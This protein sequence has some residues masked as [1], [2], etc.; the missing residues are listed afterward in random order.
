M[1]YY[2]TFTPIQKLLHLFCLQF[3]P[4]PCMDIREDA[5]CSPIARALLFF[6]FLKFISS[7]VL[8]QLQQLNQNNLSKMGRCMDA[9][10]YFEH[11][12]M[13]KLLL[14]QSASYFTVKIRDHIVFTIQQF[15]LKFKHVISHLGEQRITVTPL[16]HKFFGFNFFC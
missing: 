6:S 13:N 3:P 12:R 16:D 8:S 1:A 7:T 4:S 9:C 11:I 14:Q 5:N 10:L 2:F 15:S